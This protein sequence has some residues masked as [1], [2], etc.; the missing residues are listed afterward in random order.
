MPKL[1][2]L[3]IKIVTGEQGM[4][5]PVHFSINSHVVPFENIPGGTGAGQTFE[6][7]FE[8][9]S[10]AHSL[11]LVGPEKGEWNIREME[12]SFDSENIEPYSVRYGE[13][14]LDATNEVNLWQ[15]PPLKTFDV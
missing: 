9:N 10:F 4:D 13:V 12:V 6:G 2:R 5:E 11:T 14:T 3:N 15:D 8:I 1:N 7:D